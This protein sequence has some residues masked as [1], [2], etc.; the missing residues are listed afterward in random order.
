MSLQCYYW[1]LYILEF[2]NNLRKFWIFRISNIF[3]SWVLTSSLDDHSITGLIGFISM[4][5]LHQYIQT[6]NEGSKLDL[7]RKLVFQFQ[8]NEHSYLQLM[9]PTP[10][11]MSYDENIK[12]S[13]PKHMESVLP[14]S[15]RW[16]LSLLTL[17][18]LQN[19][20]LMKLNTKW[21]I[22]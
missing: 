5:W 4:L 18:A 15:P 14:K 7:K 1:L 21:I 9:E 6:T 16:F 3:H 8:N 11:S 10:L 13:F 22:T 12:T 19:K 17:P 2:S 20:I